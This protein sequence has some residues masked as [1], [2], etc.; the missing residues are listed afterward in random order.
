MAVSVDV[1]SE[2]TKLLNEERISKHSLGD[3]QRRDFVRVEEIV[4]QAIESG[5]EGKLQEFCESYINENPNS[6]YA[7]YAIGLINRY[8]LHA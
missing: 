2:M 5:D 1:V 8:L 7:F 3:Y 6:V 4:D